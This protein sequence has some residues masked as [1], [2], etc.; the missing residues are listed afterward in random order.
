MPISMFPLFAR[1][2]T[3]LAADI[4]SDESPVRGSLAVPILLY[5]V[6]SA[7]LNGATSAPAVPTLAEVSEYRKEALGFLVGGVLAVQG[8]LLESMPAVLLH[9]G[10]PSGDAI[11][12]LVATWIRTGMLESDWQA[13]VDL[14]ERGYQPEQFDTVFR[15][16][17]DYVEWGGG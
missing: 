13:V 14:I 16:F 3:A 1:L 8:R 5:H 10:T 2:V 9:P 17:R 7:A 12:Q 15:S 4:E 11:G 6:W